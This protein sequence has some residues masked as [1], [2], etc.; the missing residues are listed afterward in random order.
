VRFLTNG[1][2]AVVKT[3][4]YDSY[5]SILDQTGTLVNAY[6]YTGREFDA[7]SGLYYYR[8]RY[9][10][11]TIGRFIQ[12]DPVGFEGGLNFYAYVANNPVNYVDPQGKWIHILIGAAT[13]VATGFIIAKLTGSCYSWKDA[14]VD[15]GTGALGAGLLSKLNKLNRIRQLRNVAKSKGLTNLGRT[16]YTE[17]WQNAAN[18]IERLNI[19]F[20]AAKNAGLQPGSYRP[21][22]DYRI[23]PG[24]FWDP[25][26]GA[27]G[28][29]GALS[30]IP[31]EPPLSAG[32]AAG[33]GAATGGAGGAARAGKDC[34]CK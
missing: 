5:G 13:S 19:K 20:G 14:L 22:F 23:G 18:T 15:A 32:A 17:T 26:T 24:T 31:L 4:S 21:R 6:S 27:T 25:F 3:F 7:E 11:P 34:G 8:A 29:K 30:H 33:A 2:G 16:G 1:A 10:D 28:P 12:E 9:Y